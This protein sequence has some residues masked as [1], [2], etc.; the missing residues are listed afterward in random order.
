MYTI[1][2]G[3]STHHAWLG[4]GRKICFFPCEAQR[5]RR[6]VNLSCSQCAYCTWITQQGRNLSWEFIYLFCE[7]SLEDVQSLPCRFYS[8]LRNTSE[9]CSVPRWRLY[10]MDVVCFMDCRHHHLYKYDTH[11]GLFSSSIP[12]CILSF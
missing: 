11:S 10:L 2:T 5:S 4:C 1:K 8:H 9:D 6:I 12:C 3:L 7:K